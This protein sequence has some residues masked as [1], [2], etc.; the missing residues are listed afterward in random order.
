LSEG[1]SVLFKK[2]FGLHF[3]QNTI[4]V[5]WK[6]EDEGCDATED[7]RRTNADPIKIKPTIIVKLYCCE[8]P[9]T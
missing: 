9:T 5:D 3:V 1:I 8:K 4:K 7:A 2:I 6:T